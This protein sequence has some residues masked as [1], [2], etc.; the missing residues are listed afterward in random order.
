MGAGRSGTTLLAT[1]L[2]NSKEITTL[3]EM[4]QFLDY[5]LN[6][7][8]CSCGQAL[9]HCEFWAPVVDRLKSN[10]NL[11]A[12]IK[13]NKHNKKVESHGHILSS[14]F[15]S[16]AVYQEFQKE[17]FTQ[18]KAVHKTKLVLDSAKYIS[19]AIQLSRTPGLD[20]KIIYMVRDVRG[21][22]FSFGKQVQTTKPAISAI[23]YYL[24][25]N[26]FGLLTQLVLGKN[27]VLRLRYESL[28]SQPKETLDTL[29]GFLNTDLQQ[30]HDKLANNK[31]F[32]MPHLVAGNRLKT[33]KQI[34]LKPD[35]AW[36][37]SQSRLKQILYYLLTLPLQLIFKYRV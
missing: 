2:G 12:L 37:D 23:F 29:Q 28:V 35:F 34:I 24:L 8:P 7:E 25:I 1:L 33:N 30:V 5:V 27:K 26:K 11:D 36:K 6:Q 16:N 3:G 20:V 9:Q 13:A 22:V 15:A 14:L 19:R 10:H 4:H 18:V 31:P 21:V 32:A 17:V